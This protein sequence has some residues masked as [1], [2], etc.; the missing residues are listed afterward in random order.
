M[1]SAALMASPANVVPGLKGLSVFYKTLFCASPSKQ[2]FCQDSEVFEA[3][4]SAQSSSF[5]V[6]LCSRAPSEFV[7]KYNSQPSSCF[8]FFHTIPLYITCISLLFAILA[9]HFLL[10]SCLSIRI[11]PDSVWPIN[12]GHL[13]EDIVVWKNTKL[14]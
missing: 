9:A 2:A 13:E 7:L 11:A 8:P 12:N 14:S 1:R 5:Q 3:W 10:G 4:S 6:L